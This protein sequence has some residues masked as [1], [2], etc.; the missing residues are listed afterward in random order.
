MCSSAGSWHCSWH[1]GR[2]PEGSCPG[3]CQAPVASLA[4]CH[5]G[6]GTWQWRV[7]TKG[8]T[9]LSCPCLLGSQSHPNGSSDTQSGSSGWFRPASPPGKLNHSPEGT[10]SHTNPFTALGL[11]PA[12][13]SSC[14]PMPTLSLQGT[15]MGSSPP[16]E[17]PGG[18]GV[19]GDM[20]QLCLAVSQHN[21]WGIQPCFH[22]GSDHSS[23]T[24]RSAPF[25]ENI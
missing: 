10:S 19:P 21:E 9:L 25:H 2:D 11:C 16:E 15:G 14:S 5:L 24:A 8:R 7:D 20:G 13:P 23:V 12:V 17:A 1:G 3:S 6:G 22:V 4:L 18:T